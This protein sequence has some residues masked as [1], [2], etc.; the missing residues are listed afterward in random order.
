MKALQ[1]FKAMETTHPT[2]RHNILQYE[3]SNSHYFTE[4]LQEPS[5]SSLNWVRWV[6]SKLLQ[7]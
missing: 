3:S 1:S 7:P 4:R 5:T 6:Q 2:T